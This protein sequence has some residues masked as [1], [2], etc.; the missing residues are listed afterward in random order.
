MKKLFSI[1]LALVMCL[2]VLSFAVADEEIK[3]VY[4]SPEDDESAIAVDNAIIEKFVAAHPGVSI[5]LQHGSL[6][7]ILAKI[8]AMAIAGTTPDFAFFSPRY[9]AAM[10]EGGYLEELTD[11]YKEIGDIPASFVTPTSSE[12]IYDIPCVMDSICLYYRTDLFEAAGITPPTNWDEWL[13]AAEKLTQDTDGDGVNDIFG[14]TLMGGIPDDYFGFTPILWANGAEFFNADGSAA[15]DSPAAIEALDFAKKLAPFCPPG[16]ENVN[17]SDNLVLF[18][19]GKTAMV[20]APGRVMLSIEEYSPDL[21][22]KI[23]MVAVPAGPSGDKPVTKVSINDFVV[24]NNTKHPELCKEFIKFYMSD[25]SYELFLTNSA[26]GHMLPTRNA[27]LEDEAY[28]NSEK[29][30]YKA[31]K[32]KKSLGLAFD[33]GSDYVLRNGGAYNPNL[34]EGLASTVMAQQINKMYLG[35]VTAAECAKTIADTWREDFGIN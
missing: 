27:Y 24:F 13:A 2:S 33:Y 14:M 32:V 11:L 3:L 12:A 34:S 26:P 4:W 17:Y 7:D 35:E 31:D 20:L 15:I 28:L 25:E 30:A 21:L 18:A 22:D 29:I 1:I 19:S 6:S 10:V 23:D 5:E 9:V 16:M 8:S